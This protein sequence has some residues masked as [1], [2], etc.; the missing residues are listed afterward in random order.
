MVRTWSDVNKESVRWRLLRARR[1]CGQHPPERPIGL[2]VDSAK[3]LFFD[4]F[5]GNARIVPT[6][7]H[8]IVSANK[9]RPQSAAPKERNIRNRQCITTVNLLGRLRMSLTLFLSL[10]APV[11]SSVWSGDI[12]NVR[13]Q[14]G[15]RFRDGRAR[16]WCALSSSLPWSNDSWLQASRGSKSA[17]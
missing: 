16:A 4:W 1:R 14:R 2:L 17:I 13:P 3:H 8:K 7:E 10:L 6:I 15:P 12:Q 9:R 5:R 11:F